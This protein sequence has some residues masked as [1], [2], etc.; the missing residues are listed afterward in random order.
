VPEITA[1]QRR[2]PPIQRRQNPQVQGSL[3]MEPTR[4]N[5]NHCARLPDGPMSLDE[6][7]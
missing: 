4:L 5:A 3:E 7:D 1:D 6:A 2:F